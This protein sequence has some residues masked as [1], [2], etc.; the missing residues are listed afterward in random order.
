MRWIEIVGERRGVRGRRCAIEAAIAVQM[1][2]GEYHAG[3]RPV[4]GGDPASAMLQ[5]AAALRPLP[6]PMTKMRR[7]FVEG[8][9]FTTWSNKR[10][11]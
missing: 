2:W 3:R 10:S 8:L 11:R 4:G 9:S 5:P 1:E 7:G 6:L